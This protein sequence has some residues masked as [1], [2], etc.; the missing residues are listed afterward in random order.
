M[1]NTGLLLTNP[2]VRK[3][4]NCE[5]TDAQKHVTY[6]GIAFK[7]IFSCCSRWSASPCFRF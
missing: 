3:V 5:D 1:Q 7:V 2:I 6:K 4:A